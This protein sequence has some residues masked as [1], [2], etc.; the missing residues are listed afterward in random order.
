MKK[1]N[2]EEEWS[3]VKGRHKKWNIKMLG[4]SR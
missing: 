3:T 1:E 4:V 2:E